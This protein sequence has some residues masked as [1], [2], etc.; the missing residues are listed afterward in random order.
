[1]SYGEV[2]KENKQKLFSLLKE[3]QTAKVKAQICD[4]Y[5]YWLRVCNQNEIPRTFLNTVCEKCVL[6]KITNIEVAEN[7]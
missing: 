4:E 6:N 1:M 2:Y 3:D 5:C 7:G